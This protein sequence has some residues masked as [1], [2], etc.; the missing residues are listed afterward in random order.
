MKTSFCNRIYL[1][2]IVG[3]VTIL[4]YWCV[5]GKNKQRNKETNKYTY[6]HAEKTE[7]NRCKLMFSFLENF[8]KQNSFPEATSSKAGQENPAF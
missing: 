5:V 6:T 2:G 4:V 7:I 3:S 8:K 1:H